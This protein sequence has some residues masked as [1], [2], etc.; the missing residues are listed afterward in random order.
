MPK[1]ESAQTA[2]DTSTVIAAL[3]TWHEDHESASSSLSEVLSSRSGVLP[4]RVLVEAFSVM[5]RMPAPHR[6]APKDAF[7]LLEGTFGTSTPVLQLPKET[8]W[9]FLSGLA[10]E[11]VTGG[12]VYDAEIIE[13]A[14]QAGVK[15]ILTLNRRHFERLA[16][17]DIRIL[18]PGEPTRSE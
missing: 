14:R 10:Q 16:P 12:A 13:C 15:N 11:G 8:Y 17:D 9:E 6:L 4:S 2:L 3:Q 18:V 1:N 7:T 5:T